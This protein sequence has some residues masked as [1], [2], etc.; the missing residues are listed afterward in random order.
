ELSIMRI[1]V[2]SCAFAALILSSTLA[3][4]ADSKFKFP[5]DGNGLLDYCGEVVN[6]LESPPTQVDPEKQLKFG[7]C[8]GYL[9]ATEDRIQNWRMT[10][11][12]Q[13]MSY[14]QEGKPAPSHM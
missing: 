13:V 6:E 7:W 8:V 4:S 14:Q 2:V 9:Q 10:G 1:V 3:H 5:S 12:I 11:A